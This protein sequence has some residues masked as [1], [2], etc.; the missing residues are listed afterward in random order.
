MSFEPDVEK[1]EAWHPAEAAARFAGIDAPWYV[2][3]GWSI[4]LFLGGRHREHEDLE[5]AIPAHRLDDF[6]AALDGLEIFVVG[7]PRD[8]HV[9]L[10]ADARG[11]LAETHQT[12][13]GEPDGGLWRIDLFREESDDETWI[14]RRDD[15]IRLP[16][17]EAILRT[18]DG[19]PYGR[20]E[21]ALLYKAKHRREKD[22]ADFEAALSRLGEPARARLRDWIGLVHPGH[23]WIERLA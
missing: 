7:V 10:L 21:I 4:D 2:A 12:W 11:A 19:V 17:S 22:E 16:F 9:T 3:A 6:V 13:V 1:W 20:P 14:C 18:D 15:R 8:G 23:A 5:V